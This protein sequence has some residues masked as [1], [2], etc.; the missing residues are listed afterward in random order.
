MDLYRL[1]Y[2]P[3]PINHQPFFRLREQIRFAA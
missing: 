1:H 2:Q 3:L